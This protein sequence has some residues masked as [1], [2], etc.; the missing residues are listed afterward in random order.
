MSK[1]NAKQTLIMVVALP[2]LLLA[3]SGA[4]SATILDTRPQAGSGQQ[5]TAL[6]GQV[7]H[8]LLMLPYYGVFDFISFTVEPGDTVVLTGQAAWA[9]LKS[10]AERAVS[11]IKNV[12][13]VVNRIEILPLSS[14]DN[15]VRRAAYCAIFSRP[16]F[17]KYAIQAASPIR[18]IVKNGNITLNGVVGS[19][20]DKTLAY[21]AARSVPGT[22]AVTDNLTIG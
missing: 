8:E 20:M 4:G 11:R 14:Y 22:F 2:V 13:K 16:G 6:E 3:L 21:L 17:E 1:Q 19:R 9:P 12:S 7:R 15:S 5:L 10:D 18:I